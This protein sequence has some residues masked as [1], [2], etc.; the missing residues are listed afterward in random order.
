MSKRTINQRI[1]ELFLTDSRDFLRRY[2]VLLEISLNGNVGMRYKLLTELLFA[3]ECSI[4]AMIFL[5]STDNESTTYGKIFEH[6]LNKLL[7]KLSSKEKDKCSKYIDQILIGCKIDIRY[8]AEGN[9]KFRNSNDYE[10]KYYDTIVDHSW[11]KSVYENLNKL[12]Q[13]VNSKI[14]NKDF[15]LIN[16]NNENIEA[17]F[18]EEEKITNLER[19]K[20]TQ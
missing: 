13:Y 4:K 7:N 9:K 8:L 14:P 20:K 10:Q 1:A 11:H 15:E 17:M 3:T 6:D 5:E 19:T 2:K 12:E 16:F 18:K